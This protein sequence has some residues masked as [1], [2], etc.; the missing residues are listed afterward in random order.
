MLVYRGGGVNSIGCRY[1]AVGTKSNSCCRVLEGCVGM[2]RLNGDVDENIL[3]SEVSRR[4][5]IFA[6]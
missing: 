5:S 1:M 3:G 4:E 6:W 2:E